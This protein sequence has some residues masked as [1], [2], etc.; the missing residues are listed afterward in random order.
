MNFTQEV[1]VPTANFFGKQFYG[2]QIQA[3]S[4][5]MGLSVFDDVISAFPDKISSIPFNYNGSQGSFFNTPGGAN[6]GMFA[7]NRVA[8]TAGEYVM[9][10][11]SVSS[12]G[13]DF[14]DDINNLRLPAPGFAN[15]GIVGG[16]SGSSTASPSTSN[17][18]VGSINITV[19]VDKDGNTSESQSMEGGTSADGEREKDFANRIK[20]MVVNVINEEKRVSGS[21]FTRRK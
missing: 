8:L 18:D 10:R 4:D 16:S 21:L 3:G 6:G 9:S 7:T 5:A 20:S 19:N 1:R 13:K 2:T 17:A 11:D 12:L 14:L 15:G